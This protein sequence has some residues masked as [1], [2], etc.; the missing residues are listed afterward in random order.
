MRKASVYKR[1]SLNRYAISI[2]SISANG[3]L[4]TPLYTRRPSSA[5]YKSV[6]IGIDV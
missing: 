6:L 1:T 4:G 2:I 3:E 5:R